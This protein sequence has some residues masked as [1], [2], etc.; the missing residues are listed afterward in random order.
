M[1]PFLQPPVRQRHRLLLTLFLLGMTPAYAADSI[2]LAKDL[3]ASIAL[4]GL[5]CGQVV[6]VSPQ[7]E[8]DNL[9]TCSDG[10]RYRIYVNAQGRVAAEKR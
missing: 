5:P 1:N 6:S 7:G 9:V 3:T 4:L 10:N 8:R 2:A